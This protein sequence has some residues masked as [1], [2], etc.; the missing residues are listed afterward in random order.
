[1]AF[2]GERWYAAPPAGWPAVLALGVLATPFALALANTGAVCAV[3]RAFDRED[4]GSFAVAARTAMAG[5]LVVSVGVIG[6]ASQGLE[7]PGALLLWAA[8]PTVGAITGYEASRPRQT[9]AAG[10]P[11][12]ALVS[13]AD[14]SLRWDIPIP[15]LR[16]AQGPEHR[17][18]IG[19]S[20]DLVSVTF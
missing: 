12:P 15:W 18:S 4:H 5:A 3:G 2:D 7:N 16:L 19:Y 14:R 8:L 11:A 17:S 9:G 1:M 13:I 10:R 20:V 6:S